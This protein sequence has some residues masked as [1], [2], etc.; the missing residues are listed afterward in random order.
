MSQ[1]V[2]M[3]EVKDLVLWTENPRDPI[4]SDCKD[5]EIVDRAV[6]DRGRKWGL[7][8]LAKEMGD[9]YDFS[10]IPT[11]VMK[12][13]VPIVY[14]GNRR[15]VLAKISLGYVSAGVLGN[16]ALPD[17]PHKIPCNVCSE[18]TAL[19]SIYRKHSE[20][21]SWDPLERDIFANK[22]LNKPKTAFLLLEEATGMI[23]DN[24]HLNQRF[25]R[26]EIFN[27]ESLKRLGFAVVDGAIHA[28]YSQDKAISILN[29]L[30]EKVKD[31]V[32]TTRKRRG[33]VVE[34][35][36][37]SSQKLLDECKSNE[38]KKLSINSGMS[39]PKID[40]PPRQSR[41]TKP[42]GQYIFGGKLYLEL[43][44][45]SDLYRDIWDLYNFYLDNQ[46]KLSRTFPSMIRMSLRLLCESA[47]NDKGEKMD[48]Y[49]K[50]RFAS[51]KETLDQDEKTTISNQNI[52]ENTI[53]Q[54]LH[55][56][57]HNYSA[58]S[59]MDQTLALS[60]IVGRIVTV[61]HGKDGV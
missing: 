26:D 49:L 30:S 61:S 11:V 40:A 5:Q 39:K 12:D 36:A 45:V 14:D 34:V 24:A 8:K 38:L 54:L 55:T 53:V 18:Q 41:R 2:R 35:L 43:G 21:G 37:P 48:R 17:V 32:I 29:D 44:E 57:A 10:E 3:L 51:A 50:Q 52:S 42:I 60:L 16:T 47:A 7:S 4:A 1:E 58:S 25:V 28:R 20:S 23:S 46:R 59:N 6:L 27:E 19:K 56:G 15:V 33:E 22:Y 31:K 13:G 9:F